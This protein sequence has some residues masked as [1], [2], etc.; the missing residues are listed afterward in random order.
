MAVQLQNIA[1]PITIANT[2]K[3]K[4]T[5]FSEVRRN[6]EGTVIATGTARVDWT[7]SVMSQADFDWFHQTILN[8]N[9]SLRT[10][11]NRLYNERQV[12]TAYST[13]VVLQPTYEYY[14]GG[15]YWNVVVVIDNIQI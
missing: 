2:G 6:G 10:V 14:S 5:P 1:I 15:N 4:F 9:P 13:C 11:T 3:Y 12:E 8:G 7:F